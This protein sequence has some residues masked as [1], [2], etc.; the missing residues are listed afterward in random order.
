MAGLSYD[1]CSC[2]DPRTCR[3]SAP[4]TNWSQPLLYAMDF[5][6]RLCVLRHPPDRAA[7]ASLDEQTTEVTEASSLVHTS[8]RT[9]HDARPDRAERG[10]TVRPWRAR[11]AL[12]GHAG[13]RLCSAFQ[14]RELGASDALCQPSMSSTSCEAVRPDSASMASGQSGSRRLGDGLLIRISS[15][16]GAPAPHEPGDPPTPRS[17]SSAWS[18]GEERAP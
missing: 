12:A 13:L 15:Q 6:P 4:S 2:A 17:T 8:A 11:C 18:A 14:A 9:G 10:R 3:S 7:P 1:P 16:L 5:R